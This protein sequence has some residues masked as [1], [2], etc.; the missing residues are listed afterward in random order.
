VSTDE[1][2]IALPKLYGAPAY[3]RP[4]RNFDELPRPLDEDDLPIEA[5][6]TAEDVQ[7]NGY[8]SGGSGNGTAVAT[9][10]RPALEA[11]PFSLKSLGRFLSGR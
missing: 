10:A 8:A 11:R 6:R 4:P 1:Y 5:M 7:L 3:A 2:H 9:H